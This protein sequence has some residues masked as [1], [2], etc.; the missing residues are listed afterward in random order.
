MD[1]D[2]ENIEGK[3]QPAKELP[4]FEL[5]LC[6][7]AEALNILGNHKAQ[8]I[9]HDVL[10]VFPAN[11]RWSGEALVA[12]HNAFPEYRRQGYDL[13]RCM[14]CIVADCFRLRAHLEEE[15]LIQTVEGC[16]GAGAITKALLRRKCRSKAFDLAYGPDHDMNTGQGYRN[17][18][19]CIHRT[20][21]GAL[22][23]MAV[24]CK[25]WG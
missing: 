15:E 21:E 19:Q 4:E 1:L 7:A 20:T 22:Q 25:S 18:I 8:E 6:A 5:G 17:W 23:W 2:T 12:V 11:D 14:Q 9:S 16:S 24:M 10:Y 13:V 3:W